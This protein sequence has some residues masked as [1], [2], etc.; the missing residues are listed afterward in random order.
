VKK[1]TKV[2]PPFLIA[3]QR[4]N[5]WEYLTGRHFWTSIPKGSGV[6]LDSFTA[7][8]SFVFSLD[9][10]QGDATLSSYMRFEDGE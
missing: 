8:R 2:V 3:V 4:A 6:F 1:M 9:T 10:C 7:P 5:G